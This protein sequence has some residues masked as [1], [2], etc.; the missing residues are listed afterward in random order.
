MSGLEATPDRVAPEACFDPL[1]E[2][3]EAQKAGSEEASRDQ[4]NASAEQ[5]LRYEC[6]AESHQDDSHTAFGTPAAHEVQVTEALLQAR[7]LALEGV[8]F[9]LLSLFCLQYAPSYPKAS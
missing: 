7:Y 5:A 4:S 3:R 9:A 8:D 6:G 1:V 2:S